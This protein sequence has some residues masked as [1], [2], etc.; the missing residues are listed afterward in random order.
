MFDLFG[1]TSLRR[2]IETLEGEVEELKGNLEDSQVLMVWQKETL[3]GL[4]NERELA[5]D[6]RVPHRYSTTEEIKSIGS[7]GTD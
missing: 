1:K 3:E 5:K 7:G 4:I 6:A 2:R